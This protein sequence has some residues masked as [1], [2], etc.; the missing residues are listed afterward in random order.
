[1]LAL[2]LD[3]LDGLYP[4][5]AVFDAHSPKS[6]THSSPKNAKTASF[7]RGS[8]EMPGFEEIR[9]PVTT[10]EVTGVHGYF[11]IYKKQASL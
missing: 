5:T 1:M 11:L 9:S 3:G 10:D 6:W 2:G 4:Q 8:V 7:D